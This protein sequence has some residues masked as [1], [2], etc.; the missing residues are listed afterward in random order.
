MIN[1]I[2]YHIH[3][4]CHV[5]MY[6]HMP[7]YHLGSIVCLIHA[8]NLLRNCQCNS[9]QIRR[10][11][12][13]ILIFVLLYLQVQYILIIFFIVIFIHFLLLNY[14]INYYCYYYC[15]FL[16]FLDSLIHQ[17]EMFMNLLRLCLG[18]I[19][20]NAL[21]VGWSLIEL[22]GYGDRRDGFGYYYCGIIII[23]VMSII[24]YCCKSFYCDA[25]SFA[26][27]WHVIIV[28]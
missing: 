21:G 17:A 2:V 23:I 15:N 1:C 19:C 28:C 18:F 3:R 9:H 13:L 27:C 20:L 14:I 8:W 5:W 4:I 25:I 22:K 24:C 26:F 12:S 10:I 11:S 16:Y 6:L 7:V